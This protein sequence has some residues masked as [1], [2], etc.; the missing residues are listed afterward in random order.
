MQFCGQL[1][2]V[3]DEKLKAVLKKKKQKK[4]PKENPSGFYRGL[5]KVITTERC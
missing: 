4:T 1:K 3:G 2:S 5:C